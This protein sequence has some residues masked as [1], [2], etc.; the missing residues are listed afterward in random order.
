MGSMV[1]KGSNLVEET[2]NLQSFALA[3]E[4]KSLFLF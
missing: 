4:L 1:A 3:S 2:P